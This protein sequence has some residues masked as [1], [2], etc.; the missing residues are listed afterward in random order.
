[1]SRAVFDCRG[2]SVAK[3]SANQRFIAYGTLQGRGCFS[4]YVSSYFVDCSH[5]STKNIETEEEKY[6][7]LII[8]G[9][10]TCVVVHGFWFQSRDAFFLILVV[11]CF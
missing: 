6:E 5:T 11:L 9:I 2:V 8:V 7:S 3:V 4:F 1:V 10:E